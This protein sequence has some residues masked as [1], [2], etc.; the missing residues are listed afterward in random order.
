MLTRQ[1]KIELYRPFPT[2]RDKSQFA[3]WVIPF[4][5]GASPYAV[6]CRP[7]PTSRD[8]SRLAFDKEFGST[9]ISLPKFLTAESIRFTCPDMSGYLTQVNKQE[10][11]LPN[12]LSSAASVF[13]IYQ[14]FGGYP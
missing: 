11:R 7:F 5:V 9:R 12:K 2:R 13:C 1:F 8:K 4:Y 6:L 14:P 3:L 10:Q